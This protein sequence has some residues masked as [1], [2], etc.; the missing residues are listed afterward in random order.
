[1]TL[2]EEIKEIEKIANQDKEFL[3]EKLRDELDSSYYT[4]IKERAVAVKAM[5]VIK[6]LEA[7]IEMQNQ[8]IFSSALLLEYF[9]NQEEIEIL[10]RD[11]FR[12][13]KI[14]NSGIN[15]RL[16]TDSLVCNVYSISRQARKVFEQTK[17]LLEE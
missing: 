3:L 16:R 14:G 7:I 8:I 17:T 13:P 11:F 15:E 2:N 4:S 6:K 10:K 5:S 9:P 1:M 12:D